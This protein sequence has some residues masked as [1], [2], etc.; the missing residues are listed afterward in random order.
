M[1]SHCIV[2]RRHEE[3]EEEEYVSIHT[4]YNVPVLAKA[5]E[6]EREERNEPKPESHKQTEECEEGEGE[7][8]S[9]PGLAKTR[10]DEGEEGPF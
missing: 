1:E 5:R 3:D 9:Q 4:V 8:V 2:S 6:K 10:T 7:G